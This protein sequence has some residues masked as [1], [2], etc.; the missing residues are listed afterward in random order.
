LSEAKK[1]PE[2]LPHV[3][4]LFPDPIDAA[5]DATDE[6]PSCSMADALRKQLFAINQAIAVQASNLLWTM[7][8]TGAVPFSGVFVNLAAGRTNPIPIDPAACVRFGYGTWRPKHGRRRF[9]RL[10][11]SRGRCAILFLTG[12]REQQLHGIG[13]TD[14]IFCE[15]SRS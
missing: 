14:P 8:R 6:T 1:K 10:N 15:S 3:G 4:E 5:L 11:L 9:E 7:F 13:G 12:L 2:R